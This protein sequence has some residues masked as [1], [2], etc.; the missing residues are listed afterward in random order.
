[1]P[2]LVN[3]LN[4]FSV[5]HVDISCTV[6]AA[7]EPLWTEGEP[8]MAKKK[9][10]PSPQ[11]VRAKETLSPEDVAVLVG[12]KRTSAYKLLADGSIPS[13]TVGR[14]R[15]VRRADV[16]RFIEDRLGTS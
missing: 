3:G 15:R 5:Q 9:P 2:L 12:C 13:F 10:L 11:E 14:L 16:E 6:F 8:K 7:D 4:G 1:M